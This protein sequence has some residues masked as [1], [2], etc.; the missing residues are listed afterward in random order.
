MLPSH[1]GN[2]TLCKNSILGCLPRNLAKS[3][4]QIIGKSLGKSL[5]EKIIYIVWGGR[6][7]VDLYMDLGAINFKH[8]FVPVLSRE[9]TEVSYFGYVQDAVLD[10]GLDLKETTVYACGSEVMIKDACD[11]LVQH[12]LRRKRFYSDAFVS[13]N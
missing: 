3:A 11:V 13:S 9:K 2:S 7:L 12:G 10:L 1:P 8:T 6:V 4:V 5:D